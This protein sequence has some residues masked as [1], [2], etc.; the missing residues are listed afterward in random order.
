[1][2]YQGFIF[3]KHA[4]ER[5]DFRSIDR[6][7][8]VKVLQ[9]PDRTTPTDKPNTTKFIRTL[10]GRTI[11]V[12][13]TYLPDQKKW[14]SISVWVRGE[15]DRAPLFWQIMTLPFK[16]IWWLMKWGFTSLSQK[17]PSK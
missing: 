3:T 17:K 15:D 4:L 8:V 7:M 10:N 1:M 11:H 5:S 2:E 14:L 9:H 12:V 6:D 13:S 16:I